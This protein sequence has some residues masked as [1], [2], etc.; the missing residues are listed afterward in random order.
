MSFTNKQIKEVN[1]YE[2]SSDILKTHLIKISNFGTMPKSIKIW[3][4]KKRTKQV[5]Q[6]LCEN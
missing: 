6:I 3:L 2:K 5:F 1:I 4:R